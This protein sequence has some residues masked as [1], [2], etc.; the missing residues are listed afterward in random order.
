MA[1]KAFEWRDDPAGWNARL[2]SLPYPH[3]LQSW[4][5]GALQERFG[6]QLHRLAIDLNDHPRAA[7][8]I[9]EGRGA[10]PGGGS[11][12]YVPRGP[13]LADADLEG[14]REW[15]AG[16]RAL[17]ARRRVLAVRVE[18]ES[19][20]VGDLLL[21]AGYR[22]EGHVQPPV[23]QIVDLSPE[24]GGIRAGF[25]PKTRYN[26]GLAE[27]RGVTVEA[28]RD[29]GLFTALVQETAR[30][31]GI[32]LPGRSYFE[33]LL[34]VLE[35]NSR[36]YV[37]R[38]EGIALAAI[39]VAGFGPTAYYLYGGDSRQRR[40]MMPNYLLHWVAMREARRR[41]CRFYDLWGIIGQGLQQFKAGFGGQT[42]HYLGVRTLALRPAA[43]RAHR[44]LVAG[45][46]LLGRVM[47]APRRVRS[48]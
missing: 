22:S 2:L 42:V 34:E 18:P 35:S 39:L 27:R 41:G 33:A 48:G 16:I 28:T 6:W 8:S 11:F 36:L 4:E 10:V 1:W 30:R 21:R 19:R 24:E 14:W 3:L 25:K 26:L 29:V 23:S 7:A 20:A 44:A 31:Q 32:Q 47:R 15:L 40:E 37:A 17:A 12:W 5:W 13:A 43:W 46:R 45:R 9:Q 38:A